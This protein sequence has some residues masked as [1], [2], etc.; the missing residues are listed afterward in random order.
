MVPVMN[1]PYANEPVAPPF[2]YIWAYSAEETIVTKK[3]ICLSEVFIL[4]E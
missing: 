1:W 2:E 3:C 4:F